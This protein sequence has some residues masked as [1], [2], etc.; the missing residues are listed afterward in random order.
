MTSPAF[1][2]RGS[3]VTSKYLVSSYSTS[4]CALSC[5][6]ARQPKAFIR[7]NRVQ[8]TGRNNSERSIKAPFSQHCKNGTDS[9]QEHFART[10]EAPNEAASD[11]RTYQLCLWARANH[12]GVGYARSKALHA[13]WRRWSGN[14]D[15]RRPWVGP[16]RRSR[17]PLRLVSRP[18]L[19]LAASSP[20]V[21]ISRPQKG[22]AV[23]SSLFF[24]RCCN[25]R[26]SLFGRNR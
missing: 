19:W 15:Q 24:A 16:S 13:G 20:L 21:V 23:V 18:P 9:P 26:L 10:E 14:S 12:A 4:D 1:D 22:A 11:N 6:G 7:R 17:P 2:L 25:Q 5:D 3:R 8:Q